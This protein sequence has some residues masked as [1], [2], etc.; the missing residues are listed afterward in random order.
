MSG[1]VPRSAGGGGLEPEHPRLQQRPH[2]PAEQR[3]RWEVRAAQWRAREL[4]EA[5]F[6]SVSD[7]SLLG[8]RREGALRGLLHLQ[9][10]FL[11]L[12][13]HR[14]REERFLAAAR[15]DPILAR[16]PLVYVFAPEA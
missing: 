16:I 7:S 15:A 13:V 3:A 6:G 11:D 1:I 4:A 9:V 8:L 2:S 12:D 14:A 5:V 10:P